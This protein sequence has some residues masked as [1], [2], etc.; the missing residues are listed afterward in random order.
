MLQ[1]A[2]ISSEALANPENRIFAAAVAR[3]MENSAELTGC[4]SFGLRLAF[5]R[6]FASLGPLSLLL[7]RLPNVHEML[8]AAIEFQLMLT[9]IVSISMAESADSCLTRL[10][11]VP[12]H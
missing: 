9:D 11:L 7:K 3:L 4:D 1:D 10:D 6:S 5:A 2:G 8:R 12:G